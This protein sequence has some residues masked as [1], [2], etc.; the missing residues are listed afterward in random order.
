MPSAPGE[1]GWACSSGFQENTRSWVS[2][3]NASQQQNSSF[4]V[5]RLHVHFWSIL[6]HLC[7]DKATPLAK[8]GFGTEEGNSDINKH[9]SSLYSFL[10]R[11]RFSGNLQNED[12]HMLFTYLKRASRP[13]FSP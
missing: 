1:Q 3:G 5:L 2:F 7:V 6:G 13:P 12:D 8:L 4:L 9:R 10:T 11:V